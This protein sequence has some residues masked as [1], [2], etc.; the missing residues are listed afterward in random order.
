LEKLLRKVYNSKKLYRILIAVSPLAVALTALCYLLLLWA[1]FEASVGSL[2]K[3]VI[4]TAMPFASVTLVRRKINA[5]RPFEL[6]PFYEKKPSHSEGRGFPSRHAFSCFIIGTV[7]VVPYP[8]MGAC[9]LLLGA[10]LSVA[11]VLV[12]LHFIRDVVAGALI[13]VISGIIGILV[14]SPF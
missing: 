9:L 14:A 2:I 7:A 11:R 5:P 1:A 10:C 3:L 13:G 4:I 12:G 6:Y 8:I